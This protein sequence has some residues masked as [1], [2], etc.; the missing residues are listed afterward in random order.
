MTKVYDTIPIVSRASGFVD[1]TAVVAA[2]GQFSYA[3]LLDLSARVGSWLLD[4]RAD[5]EEARVAFL[6]RPSMAHAYTQW[7]I[8]RG[9]GMA[10]PLCVDHPAPELEYVLDDSQ[11]S[12]V[13]ADSEFEPVLR[14]L[15][16]LRKLR[17]ALAEELTGGTPGELPAV[18][19][20]RRAMLIY[21][22][23]TTSKPKGTVSTH[24]M[25]EA[26]I[27][28]LVEAWGWT[29]KDHLLHC[30]PLHHLHGIINALCCALWSGATCELLP[31]FDA[32]EVCERLAAADGTT[33]FM[34]V[35]TIYSRLIK[36][37]EEA[38]DITRTQMTE[39][40][41]KLRVMISG[42]AALPVATLEK[43]RGISG[44]TLLERYGMTEIGMALSNPLNGERAPGCVGSPLPG[45][46]VRLVDERDR[47]VEDG[48]P[49]QIQ[50]RGP[51]VFSEYWQRPEATAEAFTEE[52][53]FRTGD[54]AVREDG[55]YRILGRES[56]DI[57]KTGGY[58]VS[59]LEIEEVLRTHSSIEECA[60]V[61]IADEE[62]GQRVAA[63]VVLHGN[64]E[65]E[66]EPLRTWC[67]QLLA[68][69]KVPSILQALSELPRN[70]M[71]KV[72]K[73]AIVALFEES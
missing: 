47:T 50:V 68:P 36:K 55:V 6:V 69:Y 9:G 25:I 71:G 13:I 49:G 3:H 22:S 44:H 16:E 72:T 14:P 38:D 45:I 52:R 30:L 37:W 65:L 53:W 70:P 23:G 51:M 10:V 64:E 54:V 33:L 20:S 4:G 58:K 43:W 35:P 66:L 2:D 46:E 5:L 31:R 63:A 12:I 27:R 67:K 1:R 56:V 17:F 41:R 73:P 39:G 8:W 28:S 62:W 26:Q 60:V 18:Q 48:T 29:R 59:A 19:A 40:C 32:G 21:T 7:G 42:S 15:A 61:G 57:I 11:A 24:L 34:A